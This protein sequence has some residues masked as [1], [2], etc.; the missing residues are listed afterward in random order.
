MAVLPHLLK[1]GALCAML[2]VLQGAGCRTH[3]SAHLKGTVTVPDGTEFPAD[4]RVIYRQ[5]DPK[6]A[7]TDDWAPCLKA[8]AWV[9]LR[10]CTGKLEDSIVVKTEDRRNVFD[11]CTAMVGVDYAADLIAFVDQDHDGTLDSGE[12][13]GVWKGNPLTRERETGPVALEL[14]IDRTLP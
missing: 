11:A 8:S 9:P 10:R 2:P 7:C 1:L 14:E 5:H 4:V 12:R 3:Y 6:V 13:Y